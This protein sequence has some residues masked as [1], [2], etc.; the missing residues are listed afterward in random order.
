M[1]SANDVERGRR[2]KPGSRRRRARLAAV[3]ALYQIE[4][5]GNPVPTTIAEFRR[6]RLSGDLD[7][8]PMDDI[9]PEFF[10]ELVTGVGQH[11]SELDRR[12]AGSLTPD[13]PLERLDTVL[14]AILRAGAY[15][16]VYCS[17]TPAKVAI[18]EYMAIAD[19][20]FSGRE[21]ALVNGV[22]DTVSRKAGAG[23]TQ[24]AP[25]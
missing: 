14:R 2:N 8:V 18:S 25:P 13:W 21:P 15:E 6:H 19:S 4:L 1:S 11:R 7:G 23:G 16:L 22:L 17:Q 9:D 12:I 10:A 24:T 3:Q 5:T 20:F